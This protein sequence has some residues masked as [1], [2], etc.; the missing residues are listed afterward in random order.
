MGWCGFRDPGDS[1]GLSGV[2]QPEEDTWEAL[3]PFR[4]HIRDK[5]YSNVHQEGRQLRVICGTDTSRLPSH[6]HHILG[7]TGQCETRENG[8][9]EAHQKI[10]E[11]VDPVGSCSG[12]QL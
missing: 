9:E 3:G 7:I 10:G 6:D 12:Q 4:C 2:A 1:Y 5:L 8:Q 11:A